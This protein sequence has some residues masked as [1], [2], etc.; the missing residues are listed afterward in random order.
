M[1][2]HLRSVHII[3]MPS[4]RLWL[5]KNMGNKLP[6]R[7]GQDELDSI[8]IQ[9]IDNTQITSDTVSVYIND[10]MILPER[11]LTAAQAVL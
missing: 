5:Q 6:K 11:R 7:L 8:K 3:Q 1:Q 2:R 4:I 10:S 9:L